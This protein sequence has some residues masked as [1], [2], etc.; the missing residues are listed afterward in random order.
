MD[1]LLEVLILDDA[2]DDDLE[3]VVLDNILI[4]RDNLPERPTFNLNNLS[5][6][7]IKDNFRFERGDLPLLLRASGIP[8]EV[9]TATT[10]NKVSG[11]YLED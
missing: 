2:E 9:V 6:E 10:N 4:D 5:D 8:P 1:E 11:E 7:E 3:F